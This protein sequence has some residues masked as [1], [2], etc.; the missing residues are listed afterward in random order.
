MYDTILKAK[1]EIG[2]D[3]IGYADTAIISVATTYEEAKL[4]ACIQAERTIHE[5]RKLGL[6]VAVEKTE[7]C[8]F[9]E[10]KGKRS[11]KEDVIT[12]DGKEIKVGKK[13]KYLGV[14][15][16]TRMDFKEHFKYTY[17]RRQKR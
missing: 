3:V 11:P 6:R 7:V 12:M 17:K 14:I 9:Q 4:N 5:I 15:L 10:K 2:C 13:L 1:K 16:D 8:V